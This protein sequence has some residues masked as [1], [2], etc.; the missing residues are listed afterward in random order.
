MIGDFMGLT[1]FGS[2]NDPDMLRA[3]NQGEL[4]EYQRRQGDPRN[5]PWPSNR[6]M[7]AMLDSLY[8]STAVRKPTMTLAQ[9]DERRAAFNP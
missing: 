2:A 7:R 9:W 3:M 6:E 1:N 4:A 8:A 5:A